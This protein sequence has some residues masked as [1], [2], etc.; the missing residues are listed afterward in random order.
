MWESS[1]AFA[2]AGERRSQGCGFGRSKQ[3]RQRTAA[4]LQNLSEYGSSMKGRYFR[5]S[6][7]RVG[8]AFVRFADARRPSISEPGRRRPP[9]VLFENLK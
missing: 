8:G 3:R 5:V 2:C 6:I 4:L 1:A 9:D 7:G